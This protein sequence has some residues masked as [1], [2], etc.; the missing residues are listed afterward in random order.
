MSIKVKLRQKAIT[1]SR[2]SLYLD[3]YPAIPHPITGKPTRREFL[4]LYLYDGAKTPTERLHNKETKNLADIIWHQKENEVNKPEI[5][6]GHEKEQLRIKGL[7]EV[8]FTDYFK[9]LADKRGGTSKE[10]WASALRYLDAFTGGQLK[11]ADLNERFCNDFKEYLLTEKSARSN[12]VRI[13]NNSASVYFSKFK[14]ALRQA[15][16][17]GFLQFDLSVKVDPIKMEKTRRNFLTL[18]EVNTLIQTECDWPLIKRA[19]IFSA[20]TGLRFCD[21]EN[22]KWANVVKIEGDGYYL[23]FTAQK[24]KRV[25]TVP[26]SEGAFS[27]LGEMKG[28]TDQV[29]EG[30]YYSAAWAPYLNK[31]L[32]LAG[33]SRKITFH[34]FRHTFATLQITLGTDVYTVKEMM[35]HTDIKTTQIYAKIVDQTKRTAANKIQLNITDWK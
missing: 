20:F 32:G 24:T 11:F 18:E 8:S 2:K 35:G 26:I 22:L 34:C 17:D 10:G 1:G 9:K 3:F 30:L 15:Y 33:I 12:K 28:D 5:Y 16:K 23:N 13:A 14:S 4:N 21:I 7:G 31:W 29:F 19:A 6:S 25:E 27:L